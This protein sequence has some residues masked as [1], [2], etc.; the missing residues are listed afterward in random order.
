MGTAR[1][2]GHTVRVERKVTSTGAIYILSDVNPDD[3]LYQ[4]ARLHD[5]CAKTKL[6][7]SDLSENSFYITEATIN[8]EIAQG[9]L[10]REYICTAIEKAAQVGVSAAR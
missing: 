1:I 5:Y 7:I 4:A 10:N 2:V 6:A 3:R 9:T 8:D